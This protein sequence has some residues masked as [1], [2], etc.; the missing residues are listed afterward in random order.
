MIRTRIIPCR[1]PRGAAD[2]LNATSGATYTGVMVWHWPAYRRKGHWLSER[3]AYRF[4][5]SRTAAALHAH[6]VDAAQQ[7]FYKACAVTRALRKAGFPDARFP[8]HRRKYRTTV[9]KNTGIRR[10]GDTLVLSNGRGNRPIT[11]PLP[12]ELRDALRFLEVRLVYDRKAR[13]YAWHVVHENGKTP[14]PAPGPNVV[15]VDLGEI[16]PAV[17]GDEHEATIITC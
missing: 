1:L 2:A 13:R 15:A 5:D 4:G 3:A 14:K 11:V 12:A 10:R 7:G 8:Y 17:V 6:S 9:W 16:H